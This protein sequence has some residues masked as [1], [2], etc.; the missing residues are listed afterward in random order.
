RGLKSNQIWQMDVT[1]VPALGRMKY[2][3]VSI[4]TYS[5]MIWATPQP[6]EKVRDVRRHLTSCFAVL[7]VPTMIKTDNGPAYISKALKAFMQL[8]NINHVTGIPHSPT[9]Q[10]IVE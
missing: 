9:G 4:D 2:L 7:G 8:W 6:G 10:A 3:H 5:H 1:H